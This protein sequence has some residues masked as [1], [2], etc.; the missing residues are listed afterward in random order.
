MALRRQP[1][2]TIYLAVFPLIEPQ[3]PV[4]NNPPTIDNSGSPNQSCTIQ[5]S[6]SGQYDGLP[7]GPSVLRA[8]GV[9]VYG[10][11]F[12]VSISG[13]TGDVALRSSA[14]DP[15]PKGTWLVEQWVADYN[16]RDGQVVRQDAEGQMD[17]FAKAVPR[18]R[19]DGNTV[20]W[21]DHPGDGTPGMQGYFTKR[22]F[23]VKASN[24][25]SQCEVAL[26][27][28]FRVFNGRLTNPGWGPGNYN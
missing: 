15:K 18:P 8:N 7:N 23:Y 1:S 6:F 28:T 2:P 9:P 3:E 24:G 13:L 20:S 16:F 26:H 12:S 17:N 22:N 5:V 25:A 21:W 14:Q 19:R 10:I 27:L 11:G 4:T